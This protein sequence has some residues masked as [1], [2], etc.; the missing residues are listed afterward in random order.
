MGIVRWASVVFGAVALAVATGAAAS[1]AREGTW[2]I[3]TVAVFALL[4]SPCWAGLLSILL[5]GPDE[6]PPAHHEDSVESRWIERATS[7]AF[8]DVVLALGLATAATNIADIRPVS[9]V[10][11]LTLAMVD[12]AVRYAVL[13]RRES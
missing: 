8:L 12:A 5:A 2:E 13:Q 3:L 6:R 11:F 7:S 1:Y 9:G 10:V 4:S